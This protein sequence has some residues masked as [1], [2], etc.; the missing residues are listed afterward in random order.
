MKMPVRQ[1]LDGTF[2]SLRE[3]GETGLWNRPA[4]WAGLLLGFVGNGLRS[5][6]DHSLRSNPVRDI[7]PVK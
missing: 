6:V 2:I 4:M 1:P 5:A 7:N 3:S